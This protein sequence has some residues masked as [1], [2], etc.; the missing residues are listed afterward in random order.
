VNVLITYTFGNQVLHLKSNPSLQRF[1]M[2]PD[3]TQSITEGNLSGGDL[4]K[5]PSYF[6]TPMDELR[7]LKAQVKCGKLVQP[8]ASDSADGS[9][10]PRSDSASNRSSTGGGSVDTSISLNVSRANMSINSGGVD[11]Q[12]MNQ[13]LK[14]VFREKI[15]EYREAVYLLFGYKVDTNVVSYILING[16][17]LLSLLVRWI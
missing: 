5:Q 4:D 17:K 2:N 1:Q 10:R 11:S 12:K 15:A 13:R 9:K 3:D 7:H 8:V 6:V 16:L 14:E